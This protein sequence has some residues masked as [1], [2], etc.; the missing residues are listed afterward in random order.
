MFRCSKPSPLE[1]LTWESAEL[2]STNT[3]HDTRLIRS[4]PWSH[5]TGPSCRVDRVIKCGNLF[6]FGIS[7][8]QQTG[9]SR[10]SFAWL[11]SS[12]PHSLVCPASR[13]FLLI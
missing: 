5:C 4:F 10:L 11:T 2:G 3:T 7:S 8:M 13:P 1:E 6:L 9:H 12:L